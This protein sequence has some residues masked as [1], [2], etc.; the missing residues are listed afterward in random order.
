MTVKKGSKVKVDYTGKLE[1]GT[2][3]DTSEKQ[4]KPLE[5]EVGKGQVIKGFEENIIGMKQGE[6]KEITIEPADAYGPRDPKLI[7]EIP[8]DKIPKND[9][10]VGAILLVTLPQGVQIPGQVIE[11]KDKSIM[12]DL[13]HPLAGETLIF[14]IKVIGVS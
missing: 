5:F 9:L 1:D 3:F 8:D 13:N 2:V 4:G 7:K 10:K 6:E 12:L 11:I 14:K